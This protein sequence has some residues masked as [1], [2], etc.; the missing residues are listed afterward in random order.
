MLSAGRALVVV[1]PSGSGP[2]SG[3]PM[4]C[5]SDAG[6]EGMLIVAGHLTVHA[7]D[8]DR[9]VVDCAEAVAAAR[10]AAGCR[11][12]AVSADA[13]EPDRVNV[14]ELWDSRELLDAFCGTGPDDRMRA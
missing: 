12:F 6:L 11:D 4:S 14:F 3:R 8:R 1:V 10:N 13:V 7:S 9:Y 5:M 2:T